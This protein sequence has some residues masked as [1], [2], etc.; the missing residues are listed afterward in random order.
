MLN[1]VKKLPIVL[2]LLLIAV[3]SITQLSVRASD[4][5][6]HEQVINQIDKEIST[7]L[8]LTAGSA[9]ASA[10]ISLLP[11]DQC[12]PIANQLAE[13]SKYFLVVLS[14]LYLEKFLITIFGYI[15][16][17][18]LIPLA[19]VI[20]GI[21]YICRRKNAYQFAVK[22]AVCAIV[23][24]L[25]VPVSA[26]VSQMVYTS[27]EASI[28]STIT[29]ADRISITQS[30][31]DMSVVE[32]F[33]TWIKNAA[34]TVSEY[35]TSLLSRFVDALAVMLVTSC[36]IP[37]L[38]VLFFCWLIKL[39]FGIQIPLDRIPMHRVRN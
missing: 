3:I 39:L 11:D 25:M 2:S 29:E 34:I 32:K 9:G 17:A 33:T 27:Y 31:E 19:C 37:I 30:D 16:F 24:Y 28:E 36:F 7:V 1:I 18:F 21:G 5:E 22:F 15:S 14:A 38:V 12:T 6:N 23:L 4:P 20:A 26:K 13:F 8:K 35:V 10:L